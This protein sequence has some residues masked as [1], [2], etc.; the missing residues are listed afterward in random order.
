M[1]QDIRMAQLRQMLWAVHDEALQLLFNRYVFRTLQ[2]IVRTN[3]RLQGVPR[4]KF[5]VW[6][7]VIYGVANGI[8]VRRL[9]SDKCGPDDVSL[10]RFIDLG[11]R[12]AGAVVS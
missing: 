1:A 7:Q 11:I 8:A 10:T 9:G 2:E 4:G 5:S 3:E 6:S 12:Y